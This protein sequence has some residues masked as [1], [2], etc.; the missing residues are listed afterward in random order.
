MNV[1]NTLS[2]SAVLLA[3]TACSSD[4]DKIKEEVKEEVVQPVVVT[5]KGLFLDSAVANIDYKTQTLSGVTNAQGEFE[6]A[7]GETVTFSLGLLEFPAV[8]AQSVV[9]PLTLAGTENVNAPNVVNMLRLL[10]TLDTDANPENGITISDTAKAT[11]VPVDFNLALDEFATNPDVVNLV[12]NGGQDSFVESLITPQQAVSHFTNTLQQGGVAFDSFAGVYKIEDESVLFHFFNNN[13]YLA[14][15]WQEDAGWIGVENGDYTL[16]DTQVTFH[17]T[18]NS[19]G[20]A[21]FCSAPRGELCTDDLTLDFA[22]SDG[23][24]VLAPNSEEPLKIANV[25]VSDESVAGTWLLESE[26][27]VQ[28]MTLTAQGE[29]YLVEFDKEGHFEAGYEVGKYT[30]DA[31]TLSFVITYSYWGESLQCTGTQSSPCESGEFKVSVEDDTL[32]ILEENGEI[33]SQLTRIF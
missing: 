14:M 31:N 29:Y 22:L 1:K 30:F 4:S 32:A 9:T 21:L 7:D 27:E 6:Y 24:I 26:Y 3:L 5:K 28:Y 23:D 20:E 33:E 12:Q 15:Q 10:Q 25:S 16:T 19:D 2:I 11:A 8:N 17:T 13:E 18:G